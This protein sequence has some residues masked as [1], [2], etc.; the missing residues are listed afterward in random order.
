MA[1]VERFNVLSGILKNNIKI[2]DTYTSC[3]YLKADSSFG[4]TLNWFP[5]KYL[6]EM[7]QIK[8]F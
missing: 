4:T 8:Q 3:R 2:T 5:S 1:T 7:D 6:E